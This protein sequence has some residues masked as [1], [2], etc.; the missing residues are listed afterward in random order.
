MKPQIRVLGI[1]D[2]PFDK[3][4]KKPRDALI[5]GAFFRGGDFLD[6]LLSTKARIDGSDSTKKIA[7][8]IKKSKFMPQLQAVLLDGI[9]VAGF[10]MVDIQTLS[11][12]T[13][14]PVIVVMRNKPNI[15]RMKKALKK[16]N[17]GEKTKLIDS[18]GALIKLGNKTKLHFQYAGCIK[19]FARDVIRLTTT[20]AEIP[21]PLRIAHIIATGIV[22]GESKGDS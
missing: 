1:D 19:E 13:E 17:M 21:E 4:A 3:F 8:M 22:K 16:L 14:L 2:G 18:A 12:Q 15:S 10:N 20:N 6:G 9:A 11:K 5:V 7:E